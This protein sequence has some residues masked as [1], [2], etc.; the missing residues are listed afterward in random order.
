MNFHVQRFS[1]GILNEVSLNLNLGFVDVPSFF[2]ICI[3]KDFNA[4]YLTDGNVFFSRD[5][6]NSLL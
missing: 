1:L 4:T 6:S 2:H 3:V 5:V